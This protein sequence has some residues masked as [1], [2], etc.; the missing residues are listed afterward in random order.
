[1]ERSELY[2]RWDECLAAAMA[3]VQAGSM[4][5]TQARI[6]LGT[7]SWRERAAYRFPRLCGRFS[8][9]ARADGLRRVAER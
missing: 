5:V 7:A 4:N 3:G 6:F 8:E 1:M 9:R 2:R